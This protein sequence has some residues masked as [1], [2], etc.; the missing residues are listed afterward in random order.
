MRKCSEDNV[1]NLSKLASIE[2]QLIQ[3]ESNY[4]ELKSLYTQVKN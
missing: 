2:K 3:S 4:I 1:V